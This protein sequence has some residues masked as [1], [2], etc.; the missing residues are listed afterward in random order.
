MKKN[1]LTLMMTIIAIIGIFTYNNEDF[2]E[3]SVKTP[4]ETV[5]YNS[6]LARGNI[7][8]ASEN[9]I[10][11]NQNG[12]VNELNFELYDDVKKGDIIMTIEI[13][14]ELPE[15]TKENLSMIINDKNV[16]VLD[17]YGENLIEIRSTVDGKIL[18][19][20]VTNESPIVKSIPFISIAS[21]SDF[22]A[23]V[24]IAESQINKVLE[25]QEVSVSG[26]AIPNMLAGVVTEIMP[27]TTASFDI[28]GT[29]PEVKV[30]ALIALQNTSDDI[31][32]GSSVEAKIIV[33]KKI[34][35]IV[36]PYE[37]IFQEGDTEYVFVCED[38]FAV[39]KEIKTGY[40]LSEEIEVLS[41]ISKDEIIILDRDITEGDRVVYDE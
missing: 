4:R 28:L 38:G 31:I 12:Y 37:A 6:V 1:I 39:K 41:G 32:L 7:E 11:I 10:A 35:A 17:T 14:E 29:N 20:P 15:F 2:K 25:G 30:D 24:S 8:S 16:V 27:Y 33:D 3:V 13:S 23:R 34:D 26:D 18:K 5:V 40:E 19:L 9:Y 36:I 22:I 21:K